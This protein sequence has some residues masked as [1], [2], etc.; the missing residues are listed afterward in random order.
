MLNIP[1]FAQEETEAGFCLV[2]GHTGCLP[3]LHLEHVGGYTSVR[4]LAL[5]ESVKAGFQVGKKE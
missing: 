4:E 5:G 1:Q 3:Q 2:P